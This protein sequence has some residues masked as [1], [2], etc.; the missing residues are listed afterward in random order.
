MDFDNDISLGAAMG[1]GALRQPY[2]SVGDSACSMFDWHID[3]LAMETSYGQTLE[4]EM[5]RLQVLKS[6]LILDAP[7]EDTFE[8]MTG[9]AS[10][11]FD[12]PISLV[13]LIDLGRQ[14]FMSNR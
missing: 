4:E 8:R 5:T 6:Y 2:A 14:W 13:S 9:L 1:E 7:P 3:N 11:M 10:R 12:V